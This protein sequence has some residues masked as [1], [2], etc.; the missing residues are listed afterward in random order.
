MT[1][2]IRWAAVLFSTVAVTAGC[3]GETTRSAPPTSSTSPAPAG[4][5]V[6]TPLLARPVAAPIPVP[7]TDGRTH[8]AY[9]LL[10][11]NVLS[12]DVTVSTVTVQGGGASLLSLSGD[13]LA[14]WTR[15]LGAAA[16]PT[17]TIGP[18]QTA[19]VWID[20]TVAPE[21]VPAR[22]DHTIT[23]ALSRP[24]PPLLPA[25]MTETVAPVTV[26]TR[27]PVQ[28][29]PPLRGPKW[30]DANGCC[31][32]TP[33]R[34]A[35]NPLDGQL[36]AAERFAIDYVQL[37]PGYRLL[38]GPAGKLTSYPYFGTDIHAVADGPVVAVLDGLPEQ[39][40]GQTPTGLPLDQYAGNHVV[41]DLG[42]GNYALYAHLRTGSVKVQ[43]GQRL[44]SGQVLGSLGNTGNSDAPHLHFHVMDSPDPLRS[45]GLPFVFTSFRL[46]AQTASIDVFDTLIAGKPA[47]LRPGSHA[48]DESE[49][50]PLVSDVMDY[51]GE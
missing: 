25:I 21:N 8:L 38:N 50:T 17:T 4:E 11:T 9:E 20:A 43:P 2:L 34:M 39:V 16:K 5:P 19:A 41:Q 31:E 7:G 1:A 44:T 12:Q 29:A 13:A 51:S 6:A 45:D 14:H 28:I 3:T 32:M 42:N 24:A 26:Q 27:T 49:V 15:I 40:P 36:W 33:H 35:L 47:P 48:R 10:L 22:L 30:L 23:V 18:A 46:D 37:D